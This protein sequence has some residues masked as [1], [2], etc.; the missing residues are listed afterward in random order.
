MTDDNGE[1]DLEKL[2]RFEPL[3][4]LADHRLKH[5]T[6]HSTLNDLSA[7]D[8]VFDRNLTEKQAIFLLEGDADVTVKGK[9]DP[10]RVSAGDAKA[11]FSLT[12]PGFLEAVAMSDCKI[13]RIDGDLLDL[14]MAWD[15]LATAE[16]QAAEDDSQIDKS[17]FLTG[18]QK[19]FQKIPI[20]HIGELF[21][22]VEPIPVD[23]GELIIEEGDEGDYFY[24]IE[25]GVAEVTRKDPQSGNEMHLAELGEGTSFG[26][27]ALLT[28][29]KRNATVRMNS[30]GVL[31]RLY[32]DDFLE[33]L[34]QPD[35]NW[36]SGKEAAGL[37][38]DGAQW[39]DVRH[40]MEFH[41]SRL[42]GAAN[43]PLHELRQRMDELSTNQ[44]YICY[45]NSGRRSSAAAFSMAKTG[46][47]VSVLEGG[48]QQLMAVPVLKVG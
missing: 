37:I 12:N 29:N 10:L 38:K 13:I 30:R 26:E 35:L 14:I 22:R 20:A 11:R 17:K 40:E 4:T 43:L 36:V 32:K 33:L 47:K 48:L 9:D 41:Q 6:E 15:Q 19:S 8:V 24:L 1:I 45:C 18:V 42:P 16:T 27:D 44:H 46:L 34:N 2:K 23:S 3:A 28:S 39:L 5:L 21:E 7:G 25:F 31:L